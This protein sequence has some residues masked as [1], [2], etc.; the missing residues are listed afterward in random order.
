MFFFPEN[1][2]ISNL[3]INF[4]NGFREVFIFARFH[5][6]LKTLIIKPTI[7]MAKKVSKRINEGT[8]RDIELGEVTPESVMQDWDALAARIEAADKEIQR[9]NQSKSTLRQSR[10]KGVNISK[11]D[12]LKIQTRKGEEIIEPARIAAVA[13][14]YTQAMYSSPDTKVLAKFFPKDIIWTLEIGTA[15]TDGIR[16]AM[17]PAFAYELFGY[18]SQVAQNLMKTRGAAAAR[19]AAGTA[20]QFVLIHEVYHQI[21]QHMRRELLKPETSNLK[22]HELANIAQDVEINRDIENQMP[23]YAGVTDIIGGCFD[24]RFSQGETWEYIFD[25]Y[26][27]GKFQPPVPPGHGGQKGK[28]PGQPGNQGGTPG[29]QPGGQ[30]GQGGQPGGQGGQQGAQGGQPGGGGSQG[31]SQGGQGGNSGGPSQGEMAKKSPSYRKGYKDRLKELMEE[32]EA[33]KAAGTSFYTHALSTL[34]E[35]DQ[36]EYEQGAADAERD[37]QALLD[38]INNKNN[39]GDTGQQG[40]QNGNDQNGQNGQGEDGENNTNGQGGSDGQEGQAGD[41]EGDGK[42][43]GYGEGQDDSDD[44]VDGSGLEGAESTFDGTF[45]G[46]DVVDIDTMKEIAER[47]GQPYDIN[48]LNTDPMQKTREY[49]EQNYQELSNI[50]KGVGKGTCLGGILDNIQKMLKPKVDWRKMLKYFM[51]RPTPTGTKPT[52]SRKFLGSLEPDLKD[53][54]YTKPREKSFMKNDGIAQIFHLIDNSGSMYGSSS[55]GG[56]STFQQIFSEIIGMEKK[57]GINNSCL[58]YFAGGALDKSTIRKWNIKTKPEEILQMIQRK[59]NDVGGGTDLAESIQS[60]RKIG[61]PYFEERGQNKTLL[62]V[63]TDG[64]DYY[65]G[66]ESLPLSI[67]MNMIVMILNNSQSSMDSARQTLENINGIKKNRII[68]INTDEFLKEKKR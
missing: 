32:Y 46:I 60:L 1:L 39:G 67:R 65:G 35:I 12:K 27:T 43:N 20:F 50:G 61:T 11:I 36:E 9:R 24:D 53:A 4:A 3:L 37:F 59:K 57:C 31:G 7:I 13:R 51:N 2:A 56:K 54:K 6:Y 16:V 17:N 5:K 29:G 15:C 41:E 33:N 22:M 44:I 28:N 62:I 10:V 23:K 58:T 49:I 52:Y 55:D 8:I 66:L 30:G 34:D 38:R 45:D 47:A 48:D 21:Y 42:G 40:G 25:A 18:D 64:E 63:Y 14:H 26:N 68:C 19:G